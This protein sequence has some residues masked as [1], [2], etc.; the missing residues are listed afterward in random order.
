MSELLEVTVEIPAA[1]NAQ[2][3]RALFLPFFF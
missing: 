1:V 3:P 2:R